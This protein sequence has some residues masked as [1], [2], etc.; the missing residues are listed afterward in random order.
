MKLIIAGGRDFRH[1]VRA[2]GDLEPF[3]RVVTEV[4]SGCARGADKI[5][6]EWAAY[7]RKP[8]KRFPAD[9]DT[10]GKAAGYRR[11]VDMANYADALVAF[12]NGT[13]R[14]TRHMIDIA[15]KKGLQVTIFTYDCDELI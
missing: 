11:N 10:H 4:V 1:I 8:I 3:E 2:F 9:W 12:W 7:H 5:G 14:G 13:S 6:E 15:R